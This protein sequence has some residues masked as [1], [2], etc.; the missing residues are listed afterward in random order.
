MTPEEALKLSRPTLCGF[1]PDVILW[2]RELFDLI[3][4][5]DFSKGNLEILLSGSYGSAKSVPMAHLA[6]RHCLENKGAHALLARRARPD[7]RATIWQEVI[8]H[9]AEETIV[10]EKGVERRYGLREGRDYVKNETRMQ[11]V[12]RNGS[13]ISTGSWADRRYKRFRSLKLSFVAIE[14]IVENDA[15][16]ETAFKEIKA[17]LGRIPG[18]LEN[19]LIAATNPDSPAHW[20]HK[21]FIDA[22]SEHGGAHPTRRVIYSLTEQNV[23]LAKIYIEQLRGDLTP[24]EAERYLRGKWNEL[25]KKFIYSEYDSAAQYRAAEDYTPTRDLEVH[26]AFDF[27]IGEGKP[28]SCALFQY[29]GDTFHFFAESV[30]EGARTEEV[31]EDLE[32]RGL[33]GKQFRYVVNGDAAGKH[34]DTRSK[35]SDY[36]IIKEFLRNLEIEFRVELP[37]S[38]PPIRTR[39]NRVNAYCLN[40][41]KQRRLFVYRGCKTIDEG[42]RLTSLKKGAE[43]CED[44]S[45]AYQHVTT[46]LGYGILST[47]ANAQR[48]PQGTVQL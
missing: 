48:K 14:E 33:L 16:D 20:V 35:R 7:L 32:A 39:H 31:L 23:F 4:D 34:R 5:F 47:I 37:S 18:I 19:I 24:A 13:R 29:K 12:F 45:K 46:A 42:M 17:R 22:Q 3:R 43:Y 30:V 26:I 2:Q 8:D 41:K 15:Q 44:D 25:R 27:N 21:Y 1:S 6:I 10:D 11:I 40:D 36:D 28:L 38:N 9:L